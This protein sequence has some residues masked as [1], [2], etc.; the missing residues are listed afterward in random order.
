MGGGAA[1]T[2]QLGCLQRHKQ[3]THTQPLSDPQA[4]QQ[5]KHTAVLHV[6]VACWMLLFMC[7]CAGVDALFM[8]MSVYSRIGALTGNPVYFQKMFKNF[9]HSALTPHPQ[10]YAFFSR[11]EHLF[12]RDPPKTNPDGVF[13][14]RGN[15]WVAAAL[16]QALRFSPPADPHVATYRAV[17][18]QL[19]SRLV[20]LQGEDGCWRSSLTD[21]GE[22]LAWVWV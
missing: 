17:Y 4:H 14:S 2:L 5:H 13:W 22:R 12:Y 1:Q 16:V 19:M 20:Q 6:H 9:V 11:S 3:L 15:G 8:A 18:V 10:G 7:V 21:P